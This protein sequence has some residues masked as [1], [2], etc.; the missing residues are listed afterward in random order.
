[1]KLAC[2]R[3]GHLLEARAAQPSAA[4]GLLLEEHLASCASCRAQANLL[5]GLRTLSARGAQRLSEAER[6]RVLDSALNSPRTLPTPPERSRRRHT[7]LAAPALAALA[8]AAFVLLR[9]APS[10]RQPMAA[11]A[12]RILS[13]QLTAGGLAL[14]PDQ[15]L[16]AATPLLSLGGARLALAHAHV[17][18]RP[19]SGVNWD[20]RS[21]QLQLDRGSVFVDV[22][23]SRHASFSVRTARFSVEV[24]GTRFEVSPAA[25]RVWRGRVRVVD[26]AGMEL[27][28][29]DSASPAWQAPPSA[30]DDDADAAGDQ[31]RVSAPGSVSLERGA[32]EPSAGGDSRDGHATTTRGPTASAADG[33]EAHRPLA[34]RPRRQAPASTPS[35]A[36]GGRDPQ[37]LLTRARQQLGSGHGAAARQLLASALAL[38]L[39]PE[40]HAEALSLRAECALVEYSYDD[41]RDAYLEV[42]THWPGLSAGK[43]AL[44]AAAR[45]E[46]QHGRPERAQQ[47]LTRYL[48]ADPHGPFA[49]EAA[50]RLQALLRKL[51]P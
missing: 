51:A 33:G 24:L 46:A 40:L 2:L 32:E 42:A 44:F 25:V 31:R 17:E 22:E 50:T 47:L 38:P 35:A 12:D 34:S 15:A 49:R 1:M 37:L 9:P 48:D 19:G 29:L 10:S 27:A 30:A 39:T 18:L 7:W 16:P 36:N 8:A 4:S 23:A 6:A 20:P 11:G 21:R 3:A 43:T 5:E 13:G 28:R 26:L 41:A 45:I 14:R